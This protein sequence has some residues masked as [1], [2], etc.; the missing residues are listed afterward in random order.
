MIDDE[1]QRPAA[2]DSITIPPTTMRRWIACSRK[3]CGDACPGLK[4]RPVARA[5]SASWDRADA[6]SVAGAYRYT[7]LS[8]RGRALCAVDLRVRTPTPVRMQFVHSPGRP[9]VVAPA[10]MAE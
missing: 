2:P 7:P 3:P 8:W 10:R 4:C 6:V 1:H 5:L 9:A